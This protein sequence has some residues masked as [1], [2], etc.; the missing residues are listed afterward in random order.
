LQLNSISKTC[1]FRLREVVDQARLYKDDIYAKLKRYCEFAKRQIIRPNID[2]ADVFKSINYAVQLSKLF[3]IVFVR[4]FRQIFQQ[5]AV[6]F[7][8]Y[9][10]VCIYSVF[11]LISL[12]A[13]IFHTKC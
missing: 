11:S 10:T 5:I 2:E 8:N 12:I 1:L 9:L 3:G 6:N 13:L 7:Y 4:K